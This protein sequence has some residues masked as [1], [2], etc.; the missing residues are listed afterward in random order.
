MSAPET[1]F[2][3]RVDQIVLTDIIL[4]AGRITNK[5]GLRL[6]MALFIVPSLRINT[7]ALIGVQVYEGG[8]V[9]PI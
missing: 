9:R 2:L 7:M 3:F 1:P 5:C 8:L 4:H 6:P